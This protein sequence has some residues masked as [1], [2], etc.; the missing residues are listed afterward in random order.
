MTRIVLALVV[1]VSFSPVVHADFTATQLFLS[2][3]PVV[4][5]DFDG[6]ELQIP[7]TVSGTPARVTFAVFTKGKADLIQRVQNGFL[8]WHYVDGLDTCVYFS[9]PYDFIVG[10]NYVTWNGQTHV[11]YMQDGDS[12]PVGADDYT[13]YL[14]GYDYVSPPERATGALFNG[15]RGLVDLKQLNADGMPIDRPFFS[16]L[17]INN[18][19]GAGPILW[20]N[21]TFFKWVIGSEPLNTDL[22][23]TCWLEGDFGGNWESSISGQV[24]WDN[25][26]D[27][28]YMKR[29]SDLRQRNSVFKYQWIPNGSGARD[30]NWGQDLEWDSSTYLYCG[31]ATDNTYLFTFTH[32]RFDMTQQSTRAYIIDKENGEMLYD[33]YVQDWTKFDQYAGGAGAYFLNGGG[34]EYITYRNGYLSGGHHMCMHQMWDPHRYMETESYP[35]FVRWTNENGDWVSDSNWQDDATFK[36]SCFSPSFPKNRSLVPDSNNWFINNVSD[37]GAVSFSLFAPDGT[38]IGY[39]GTQGDGQRSNGYTDVCDIGCAYDGMY[40][41]RYAAAGSDRYGTFFVGYDSI[42]GTI[43]NQPVSVADAAPAAF[44]VEQ[45]VP[46]P[47]NPATTIRYII[48]ADS[49]VTVEVFNVAGQKLDTLVNGH[50]AAGEHSIMF[51]GSNLAAGIYFYTVKAG[52]HSRTMKMTLVK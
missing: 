24:S 21:Q 51:D 46:N 30:T 43:T 38:G 42:T 14:V 12:G 18:P 44:A 31:V 7:V 40:V 16:G 17:V 15:N 2:A 28:L 47:F 35:D 9:P 6:S 13:Y 29:D 34:P 45:N 25:D 37:Y 39:F 32:S 4:H 49:H 19:D 27:Y 50:Q 23:E 20:V 1:A 41:D 52:G 8:G 33:F 48:S 5:Y 10:S 11:T 26:F 36:W 3:A 22:I